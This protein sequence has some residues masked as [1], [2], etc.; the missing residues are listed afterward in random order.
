MELRSRCSIMQHKGI[1]YTVVQTANPSGWRWT[2]EL[3]SPLKNRTGTTA[4]RDAAVRKALAVINSL[5][6]PPVEEP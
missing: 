2:V 6:P 4:F 3:V 1:N 5:P